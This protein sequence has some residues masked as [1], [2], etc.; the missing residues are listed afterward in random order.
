MI[1]IFDL[2]DTLYPECSYV[3]SGFRAVAEFLQTRR[4]WDASDSLCFMQE[5]LQRE[6]RG[7]VFNR[8]LAHHGEHRRSAVHECIKAYRHH[9]PRIQL[10]HAARRLLDRLAPPLYLVTDGHKVVQNKK[11]QALGIEPLFAKVFITHRYGLLHSKPS[12]YCFER[13]RAREGCDWSDLVYVGDNPTKDF[14]NLTPLGVSTVRV[15][16]GEHRAAVAEPG[17][18]ATYV[19]DNLDQLPDCLPNLNWLP[20]PASIHATTSEI[21]LN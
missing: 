11:V 9:Q 18:E 3:E 20:E 6:G 19:I 16:T 1:L 10:A 13:I 5:V 12:T 21:I 15:L 17:H 7:A 14:V 8:L 2:D 4:G